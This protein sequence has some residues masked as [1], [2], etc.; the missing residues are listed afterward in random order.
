MKLFC[1]DT[2]FVANGI[3]KKIIFLSK[4]RIVV[5]KLF[6]ALEI[7]IFHRKIVTLSD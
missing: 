2:L 5:E 7:L 6:F 1:K 3:V 4:E